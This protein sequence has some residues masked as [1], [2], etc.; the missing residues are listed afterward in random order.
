[1]LS[2]QSTV[3]VGDFQRLPASQYSFEELATIYNG[4]RVD[5]IV[6]MPMNAKRM[7][8]YVRHHDVDL[9]ASVVVVD[10]E[11]KVRGIGM[12]GLRD[13]RAWIT[14]LGVIPN[15]RQQGIGRFLMDAM[16]HGA[17]E[18][19]AR[20]VQLEVIRGNEPAYR[21][22]AK[23]GFQD[24]RELLIVRRPPGMPKDMQLGSTAT[25]LQPDEIH[26]C[27]K[28][29]DAYASWIEETP[30]VLRAGSLDGLRVEFESGEGS[31]IVFQSTP[32]QLTHFVTPPNTSEIQMV[33]LL[34]HLH[35]QNPAQDTK[36]E[37]LPADS[38]AWS[39]F[40]KLGYVEAFRRIEMVLPLNT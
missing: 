19:S 32:F 26:T 13:N 39:A 29:R 35:Q 22:F 9:E 3:Q 20:L 25:L 16:L 5:Y 11:G 28:A 10:R 34:Y 18:R 36:V 30:S 31:W 23:Y 14:R 7:E 33:A 38:P 37:N 1:L 17:K 6:P 2:Q 40:Q 15:Q 21:L 27:L 8:E 24:T 12:L 4:T